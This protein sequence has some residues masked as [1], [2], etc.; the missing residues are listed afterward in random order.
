LPLQQPDLLDAF[1]AREL[2][3]IGLPPAL[4]HGEHLADFLQGEAELLALEDQ[5][6]AVAVRLAVDTRRAVA[7]RRNQSP[8]LVKAQ[9]AEGNAE[10]A[11]NFADRECRLVLAGGSDWQ[12]TVEAND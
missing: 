1:L 2:K 9:R 4:L 10:F 7:L 6:E 3:G 11:A 5:G 12:V 8:L